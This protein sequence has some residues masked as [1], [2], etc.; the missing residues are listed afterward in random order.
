VSGVRR[1]A[2]VEEI[3]DET[4]AEYQAARDAPVPGLSAA[5]VG[6]R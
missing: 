2:T 5:R 3:V 6:S 4:C 1:V